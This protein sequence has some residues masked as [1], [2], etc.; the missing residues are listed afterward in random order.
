MI[1]AIFVAGD[2]SFCKK[3]MAK[4]CELARRHDFHQIMFSEL[5]PNAP[6]AM[7]LLTSEIL[8]IVQ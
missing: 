7:Q 3:A 2:P 8:P 4:V 1:D 6:E 5:G